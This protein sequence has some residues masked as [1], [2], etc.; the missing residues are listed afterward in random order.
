MYVDMG[1]AL[2]TGQALLIGQQWATIKVD[3]KYLTWG[4]N[5]AGGELVKMT[6]PA[7]ENL[8]K[9]KVKFNGIKD[10]FPNLLE[11]DAEETLGCARRM[12]TQSVITNQFAA[13]VGFNLGL[14]WLKGMDVPSVGSRFSASSGASQ[15][16]PVQYLVSKGS[17]R[18]EV[19]VMHTKRYYEEVLANRGFGMVSTVG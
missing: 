13:T 16:L 4:R 9:F 15:A 1:C 14:W 12:D 2:R 19:E 8:V 11:P 7:P 6:D 5:R 10:V 17:S 18:Y 3:G